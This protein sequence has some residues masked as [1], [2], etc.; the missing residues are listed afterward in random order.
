MPR[1]DGRTNSLHS[2]INNFFLNFLITGGETYPFKATDG[3]DYLEKTRSIKRRLFSKAYAWETPSSS[4]LSD[5]RVE[6]G[7]VR[8]LNQ[9]GL[10]AFMLTSTPPLQFGK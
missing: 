8:G 9:G 6:Y 10:T 7:G 4:A 2:H 3:P 5:R 1:A